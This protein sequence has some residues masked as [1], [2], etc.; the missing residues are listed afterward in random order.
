VSTNDTILILSPKW[1][2]ETINSHPSLDVELQRAFSVCNYVSCSVHFQCEKQT[3]KLTHSTNFIANIILEMLNFL[4]KL[5]RLIL[6]ERYE[7]GTKKKNKNRLRNDDDSDLE[8]QAARLLSLQKKKGGGAITGVNSNHLIVSKKNMMDGGTTKSNKNASFTSK[9]K[10]D[11]KSVTE[12]V[13]A[14]PIMEKLI[15][16]GAC[17][18]S[19][20]I[21][22][23]GT[24]NTWFASRHYRKPVAITVFT[25]LRK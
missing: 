9:S 3:N 12:E 2:L 24:T 15:A 22:P 6:A 20:I 1:E 16:I 19:L 8:D 23:S 17:D 21:G 10:T 18:S 4:F 5:K 14:A 25:K 11:S 7:T 13:A